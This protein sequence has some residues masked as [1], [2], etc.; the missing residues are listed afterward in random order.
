[1]Y[2]LDAMKKGERN[3]D[4]LGELIHRGWSEVTKEHYKDGEE[5]E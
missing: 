3:V 1:M 2:V 5:N 4:K